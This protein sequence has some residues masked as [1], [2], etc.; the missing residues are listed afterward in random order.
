M[1]QM[2]ARSFALRDAFP[3]A[4]RGFQCAEEVGDIPVRQVAS[5]PPGPVVDVPFD[6]ETGEVAPKPETKPEPKKEKLKSLVKN[7]AKPAQTETKSVKA[8]PPA[9]KKPEPTREREPGD[10]DDIPPPDYG[11]PAGEEF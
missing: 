7:Q 9:E 11:G 1:L 4:L 6:A 10:D 2:R 8:E 5:L 3:D